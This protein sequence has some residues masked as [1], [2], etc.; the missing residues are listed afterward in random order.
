MPVK[1][2]TYIIGWPD[3]GA[4]YYGVR[5][6]NKLPARADLLSKY[7][8]SSK[9]VKQFRKD[10]GE[11]S[12]IIVHREF[13]DAISATAFEKDFL[14]KA[15]ITENEYWLNECIPGE[16]FTTPG[17]LKDAT[18][19]K[20]SAMAN[21]RRVLSGEDYEAAKVELKAGW[22]K[23]SHVEYWSSE[24]AKKHKEVISQVHAGKTVSDETKKKLSEKSTE[25]E[26][27]IL[28]CP[29]CGK[30]GKGRVMFRW[31]FDACGKR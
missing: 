9:I 25:R 13:D 15:A 12:V 17:P 18:K 2:Y 19:K 23:E 7:F 21:L 31:H 5:Y 8:T 4:W 14:I 24:A 22:K 1:P 27:R 10:N 28:T 3:L 26:A 6:A 20:L 30:T 11:P 16:G 29:H